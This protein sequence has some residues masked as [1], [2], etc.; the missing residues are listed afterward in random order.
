MKNL[1]FIVL[2]VLALYVSVL[3]AKKGNL[4]SVCEKGLRNLCRQKE[5]RGPR[6][7]KKYRR[8]FIL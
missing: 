2:L 4:S 5:A 3:E 6:K 1:K 7:T 8:P